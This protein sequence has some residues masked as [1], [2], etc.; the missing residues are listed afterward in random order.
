MRRLRGPCPSAHSL[1]SQA[2]IPRV[3]ELG[4][5]LVYEDHAVIFIK[6]F[7]SSPVHCLKRQPSGKRLSLVKGGARDILLQIQSVPHTNVRCIP[8]IVTGKDA[9]DRPSRIADS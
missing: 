5:Q 3:A 1:Q 2:D 6:A 9:V 8:F 7:E 4:N